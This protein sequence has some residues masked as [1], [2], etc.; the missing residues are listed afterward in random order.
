MEVSRYAIYAVPEPGSALAAF[1]AGWLGWDP[2]DG[3]E[4]PHPQ[5]DD[6]PRPLEELTERPRPYG[7]HGTIKAPFRLAEGH[8]EA[9]L[10]T[11]LDRFCAD[12]PAV[13]PAGGLRI[14]GLGRFLA[15]VP[16]DAAPELAAFAA[17]AVAAFES[18]RAPLSEIELAHRLEAGLNS[19]QKAQ[20]LRWVYPYVMED[21][22]FHVTLTGPLEPHEIAS[23]EQILQVWLEALESRDWFCRACACSVRNRMD[24]FG[25]FIA[26]CWAMARD[27]RCGRPGDSSPDPGSLSI[28]LRFCPKIE[29]LVSFFRPIAGR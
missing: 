13:N 3:V 4:V 2:E 28:T 9:E 14:G 18:F 1:G 10:G 12:R 23:V 24:G 17:E 6:L 5:I 26:P 25:S 29:K 15:L 22:R 8:T 27:L 16:A 19:R 20:L 7:F 11:A 21:F